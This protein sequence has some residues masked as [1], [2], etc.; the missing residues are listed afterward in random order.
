MLISAMVNARHWRLVR[1]V[2]TA[3]WLGTTPAPRR[4]WLPRR[5]R[6]YR[7]RLMTRWVVC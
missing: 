7:W 5:C 1:V 6:L 3:R 2:R 4:V